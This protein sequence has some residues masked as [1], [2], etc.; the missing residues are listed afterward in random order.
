MVGTWNS[1]LLWINYFQAAPSGEIGHFNQLSFCQTPHTFLTVLLDHNLLIL[2]NC[3]WH[4]TCLQ[5]LPV[6]F[7]STRFR[8]FMYNYLLSGR[9]ISTA[10]SAGAAL[11]VTSSLIDAG[12]QTTRIDNGKEYYPYTLKKRPAPTEWSLFSAT[13]FHRQN[14]R[15]LPENMYIFLCDIFLP[16][17][18]LLFRVECWNKCVLQILQVWFFSLF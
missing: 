13:I 18:F 8:S 6:S 2:L 17:S 10:I 7:W 9:S 15:L 1:L 3:T 14:F 11:A 16:P 5:A 12:G 4:L